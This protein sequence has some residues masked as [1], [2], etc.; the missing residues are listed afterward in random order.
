MKKSFIASHFLKISRTRLNFVTHMQISNEFQDGGHL[1]NLK[2]IK[3]LRL[4][5]QSNRSRPR[6]ITIIGIYPRIYRGVKT[7]GIY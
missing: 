6:L 4:F 1:E 2:P 5:N 7:V 3:M